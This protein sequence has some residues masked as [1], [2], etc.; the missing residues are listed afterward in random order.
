MGCHQE[1]G[2]EEGNAGEVLQE[3]WI[4]DGGFVGREAEGNAVVVVAGAETLYLYE[5]LGLALMDGGREKG[6]G[7]VG[8]FGGRKLMGE[9]RDRDIYTMYSSTP[10]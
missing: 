5:L 8:R 9:D 3:V 1:G 6:T 4:G 2:A 7:S 10:D